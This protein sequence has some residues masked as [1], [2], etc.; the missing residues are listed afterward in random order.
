MSFLARLFGIKADRRKEAQTGFYWLRPGK[1]ALAAGRGWTQEVVGESFYR[2]ALEKVTKGGTTYG[3]LMHQVAEIIADEHEGRPAVFVAIDGKRVGAIPKQS[4]A[5]IH[6]ELLAVAPSGS[7]T[8]K[9]QV[10][11][12]YEGHDY[13]VKLSLAR[14]LRLRER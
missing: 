2:S 1:P 10:S 6:A 11:A 7:A 3:V 13:C 12:G 9:G 5:E 14:P 4:S 8:V